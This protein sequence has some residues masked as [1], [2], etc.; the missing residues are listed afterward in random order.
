VPA[1]SPSTPSTIDTQLKRATLKLVAIGLVLAAALGLGQAPVAALAAGLPALRDETT[2]A[3]L[4]ALGVV[5]YVGMLFA[6]FGRGWIA[7]LRR[8]RAKPP[9]SPAPP[10]AE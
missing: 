6:L 4:G 7:A 9:A 3:A 10:D 2:L 5:L 1:C 8:R